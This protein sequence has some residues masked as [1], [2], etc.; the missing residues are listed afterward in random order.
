MV[1]DDHEESVMVSEDHEKSSSPLN[2]TNSTLENKES[3]PQESTI[4]SSLENKE[5]KEPVPM[6]A[7]DFLER[8]A[9]IY[10][11]CADALWKSLMGENRVMSKVYNVKSEHTINAIIETSCEMVILELNQ[12]IREIYPTNPPQVKNLFVNIY[13]NNVK[14]IF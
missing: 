2:P 7:Y 6:D 8:Q 1:S 13:N 10:K 11:I 9:N 14:I 4:I 5:N 3:Q 12:I